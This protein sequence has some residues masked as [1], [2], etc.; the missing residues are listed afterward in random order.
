V[1]DEKRTITLGET[2]MTRLRLGR[3]RGYG[4]SS[5]KWKCDVC[6]RSGYGDDLIPGQWAMGCARGHEPCRWCGR[7]LTVLMDGGPRVHAGCK[8]RPED[9]Q[10]SWD[11]AKEL[12]T[13]RRVTDA[14]GVRS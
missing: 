10:A 5:P 11:E 6:E 2:T 14:I 3:S 8:E 12:V 7:Q 13:V 1:S 4:W 9:A